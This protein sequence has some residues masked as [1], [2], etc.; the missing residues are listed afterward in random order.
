M[1]RRHKQWLPRRRLKLDKAL[2]QRQH[3]VR[4]AAERFGVVLS[5]EAYDALVRQIQA[6][7][8]RFL[9]KEST[10][11]SHFALVIGGV[12]VRAVYDRM[13]HTV[14]TVLPLDE[15]ATGAMP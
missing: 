4:R 15:L 7:Q 1:Q 6:G 11:L 10:R 5:T 3:A 9:F 13:R 8:A 14:V 12:E 2:A